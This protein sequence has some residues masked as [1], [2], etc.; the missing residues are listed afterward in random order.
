MRGLKRTRADVAS[1]ASPPCQ[2]PRAG[3]AASPPTARTARVKA[4]ND[5]RA[6]QDAMARSP[7]DQIFETMDELKRTLNKPS[8]EPAEKL[9]L[10]KVAARAQDEAHYTAGGKPINKVARLRRPTD[11]NSRFPHRGMGTHIP[12]EVHPVRR[13]H[14]T[15]RVRR[16][17]HFHARE[18]ALTRHSSEEKPSN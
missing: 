5:K 16:P 3:E 18:Q 1:P 11:L 8:M 4:S 9:A 10:A 7:P 12:V 6:C 15:K 17:D 14:Q 2:T 13:T